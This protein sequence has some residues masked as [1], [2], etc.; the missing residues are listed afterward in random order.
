VGDPQSDPPN[1]AGPRARDDIAAIAFAQVSDAIVVTDASDSVTAWNPAAERTY[2]ITA[3][4]AL[5]RPLSELLKAASLDGVPLNLV[6]LDAVRS[7]LGVRQRL[8]HR[9]LV[10]AAIG[11]QVVIDLAMTG[12]TDAA[13]AVIGAVRVMRVIGSSARLEAE[14]ATLGSL[15]VATGRG[16]SREEIAEAALAILCRATEADS[17]LIIATDGE[18]AVAG[19]IGLGDAAIER[20][21]SYGA[22]G[23]R[24]ASVLM[25]PDAALTVDLADS[26]VG[27]DIQGALADEGLSRIA[28]AGMRVSGRL[29]GVLGLGWKARSPTSP[30]GPV[31]LEAATLVASALENARLLRRVEHG[32]ELERSLTARLRALVELTRLPDAADE[33]ATIAQFLLERI[34]SVLGAASGSVGRFVDGQLVGLA[35]HLTPPAFARLQKTRS[36]SE[37]GFLRRFEGG[38][39]AY[40]QAIEPG[41]VSPEILA[42]ASA[43]GLKAYGAFSF[44]DE[45]GLAG[46]LICGFEQPA[47]ELPFDDRT[48]EAIGRVVDI[49]FANQRL[50]RVA[51]ASEER[52]RMVFERSPDAL[53][54]A[55]LEGVILEA[56]PAAVQMFGGPILGRSGL[57]LAEIDPSAMGE[58][59]QRVRDNATSSWSGNGTRLD[60]TPFPIEAEATALWVGGELRILGLVRDLTERRRLQHELLQA[61]KMEAI[62]LLVAGVAHELNNP[63][64]SIVAFSQLIRTDPNLPSELQKQA[65]LLIQ[66]SNRTRRIVQNLLDFARQRPPERVPTSV[67][68]LIQR[69]LGLQSY[70][71]GPSR[72]EAQLEIDDNLPL[73]ALDRAQIQQVLINLTLNAAQAIRTRAERGRITI[74]AVVG[75]DESGSP[76][77]RVSVAD[78]GPG[79]PAHLRSRLFVP[80]FTTK[81][82]GEGTGLGLSVSFGIAAGH[83]GSLRHE[84]GPNGLGATF[85][86]ELPVDPATADAVDDGWAWDETTPMAAPADP[87]AGREGSSGAEPPATPIRVLV[88]DDDASIRDFLARVLRRDG[89]EPI[90]AADGR[91]AL[92]LVRTEQP[93][94]ILCDH[95]MAGMSGTTFHDAVAEISPELARRFAF[96]SGDVLNPE[97]REFALARGITLLA[98]PF[99]IDSVGRTVAQIL[100]A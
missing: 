74:R 79:I 84:P 25:R 64:A 14:L 100:D 43:V 22:I 95:R 85:I 27:E 53:L 11:D 4:L 46:V 62:G 40:V 35:S 16:R 31:L 90:V 80:F 13:G 67:P 41:T 69:V 75:E 88:L 83:G 21:L 91:T 7:N 94:A 97:L 5:G 32:L 33:E 55:S 37:W 29:I 6:P 2:G 77:V 24:L 18:F 65:D 12:L 66:E 56:N 86:L 10:G 38:E 78:N 61:Q 36:V 59:L 76:V 89:Y 68:R 19:R 34:V 23:P 51:I 93:A 48:I 70:T 71:F 45:G 8:V 99:D 17:G 26:P 96:M 3:Q 49:S 15:A 98:K 1:D 52:Y 44:R 47:S 39:T 81:A 73:I 28:F 58:I 42:A 54:V 50:R 63:L 87:T 9:P 57:E 92:D 72:I 20:I 82:P 30:S 60:G